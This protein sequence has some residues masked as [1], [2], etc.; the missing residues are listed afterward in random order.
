M[1]VSPLVWTITIVATV[2]LLLVDVFIVGRR[3]HEPETREVARHLVVFIGLAVAFGIWV[4][5]IYGGQYGGEFFAGWL[6]EY[7][8]SVDNLFVFIIIMTQA[9]GAPAVPAD[10]PAHR[11]RDRAGHARHLHRRRRRRDQPV[12]LGVLPVRPVPD[13]DGVQAG[14]G[15]RHGRRALRPAED[16]HLRA[17]PPAGDRQVE[18][19]QAVDPGER[20]A[21]LDAD[22]HRGAVARHDRPAVRPRLD[23]GDL[24]PDQGAVPRLHREHLR[25]DG[26]APALLPDRRPAPAPRLPRPTAWRCSSPSSA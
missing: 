20:Q 23:P 19:R 9:P 10:R 25:A 22:V 17:D 2:S 7:S 11:H 14:Q 18:R 6:T 12:Q 13:L 5:I 24:R 1:D 21:A 26:P 4:W 15:R 8:L 16:R 3:P